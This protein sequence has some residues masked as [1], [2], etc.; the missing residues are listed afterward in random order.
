MSKMKE[1]NLRRFVALYIAGNMALGGVAY[2]EEGYQEHFMAGAATVIDDAAK[3]GDGVTGG[4]HNA[5]VDTSDITINSNGKVFQVRGGGQADAGVQAQANVNQATIKVNGGEVVDLIGGGYARNGGRAEITGKSSIDI[6]NG[7]VENVTGGGIAQSG[8]VSVRES[9]IT[10]NGDS[11]I[12]FIQG[13]GDAKGD[14]ATAN[15]AKVTITVNGGIIGVGSDETSGGGFAT[16]GTTAGEHN[17]SNVGEVTINIHNGTFR[18]NIYGGGITSDEDEDAAVPGLGTASAHVNT[19]NLNI[20]GGMI[21]ADVYAGGVTADVNGG[22]DRVTSTVDNATLNISGG[23]IN[24]NVYAGGRNAATVENSAINISGGEIDGDVSGVN[25]TNAVLNFTAGTGSTIGGTVSGFDAVTVA[26]GAKTNWQSDKT[27]SFGS[28]T[29]A[30]GGVL[31]IGGQNVIFD[32][33]PVSAIANYSRMTLSAVNG[34]FNVNG[35]VNL[36]QGATLTMQNGTI[37]TAGKGAFIS[38][39]DKTNFA[40]SGKVQWGTGASVAGDLHFGFSNITSAELADMGK[41]DEF[42]NLLQT[43]ADTDN[44]SDEQ[45]ITNAEGG[46]TAFTTKKT[47]SGLVVTEAPHTSARGVGYYTGVRQGNAYINHNIVATIHEHT[48]GLRNGESTNEFWAGIRGGS[49]DVETRFGEAEVKSQYYQLGYDWNVSTDKQKA[50]IGLYFTKIAGDSTQNGFKNDFDSAYD[51]GIYG[52]KEFSGGNYVSLI[53]RYGQIGNSLRTDVQT[54]DWKD[55]GYGL[56]M[57][58]GN[59]SMQ[60]NGLMLEPYIQLNYNHYS[61]VDFTVGADTVGLDSSAM[62]DGKLGLRLI[63]QA[64]DN[65][66]NTIFGGIAYTRG[67]SGDFSLKDR[68]NGENLGGVDHDA[69]SLELSVGI[70]RQLSQSSTLNLNAKKEF[71]DYKG[72]SVEGMVNVAF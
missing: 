41:T 57:E 1:K 65:P 48:A 6:T 14:N 46:L 25:A 11:E 69:N 19:V 2:A 29:V 28:L 49:T 39:V 3:Q 37:T 56:S 23:K 47:A 15:V 24:G 51:F 67:L 43:V 72:W 68:T 17:A 21:E 66:N 30:D 40:N 64:G 16:V 26:A 53:G 33:A 36:A 10:I 4:S 50:A 44:L 34:N 55:K 59:R 5:S 20:S 12:G 38:A 8:Q 7:T 27:H 22:A 45:S 13:G 42:S 63:K 62:L 31:N 52:T 18:N 32:F 71:G 61:A 9:V 70:N 58:F 35:E 60:A 54:T